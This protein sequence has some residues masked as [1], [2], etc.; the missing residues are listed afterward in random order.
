MSHMFDGLNWLSEIDA[1]SFDIRN[2]TY[3]SYMFINS[4][5]LEYIYRLDNLD[6][7]NVADSQ[8]MFLDFIQLSSLRTQYETK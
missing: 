5:D 6:V 3:T 7:R 4:N 1:I 8:N 2:A